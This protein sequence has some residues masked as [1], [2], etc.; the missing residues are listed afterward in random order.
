MRL[1]R[2]FVL[3]A[4]L[5]ML[6]ALP[7]GCFYD[8]CK[9][10]SDCPDGQICL[11][12]GACGLDPITCDDLQV[13]PCSG[14]DNGPQDTGLCAKEGRQELCVAGQFVTNQIEFEERL[15][16]ISGNTADYTD[17]VARASFV[18]CGNTPSGEAAVEL[19]N[20]EDD[21][22]DGTID[23]P[24]KLTDTGEPC[25][26]GGQGAC[27]QNGVWECTAG[28]R[29]CSAVDLDKQ[30]GTCDNQD[31]NCNGVV[32]EF[33]MD[34]NGDALAHEIPGDPNTTRWSAIDVDNVGYIAYEEQGVDGIT[35]IGLIASASGEAI[36]TI[37]TVRGIQPK[38]TNHIDSGGTESVLLYYVGLRES[39][40]SDGIDNDGD[41]LLDCEDE[42][43]CLNSDSRSS[44]QESACDDNQDD[45]GDNFTDCEDSQCFENVACKGVVGEEE[46][47][48]DGTDND[49][50]GDVDC[51]DRECCGD[52][53]CQGENASSNCLPEHCGNGVDDDGDGLSDCDDPECCTIAICA[54]AQACQREGGSCDNGTDDD[55]DGLAD[56]DDPDCCSFGPCN[57]N[58]VCIVEGC[59]DSGG[60][61]VDTDGD[62]FLGCEDPDCCDEAVCA[63]DNSCVVEDCTNAID[64]DN[65]GNIDCLDSECS[66]HPK[67]FETDCND[68]SDNDNDGNADCLD[69]DCVS[70]PNCRD[71]SASCSQGADFC[72]SNMDPGED[73]MTTDDDIA[74]D[75]DGDGLANCDDQSCKTGSTVCPSATEDCGNNTDDDNDGLIDCNDPECA[76]RDVSCVE[77][78]SNGIDDNADGNTDCDDIQCTTAAGCAEVCDN[79]NIDDDNNG[80]A[81]CADAACAG[82]LS[83]FENCSNRIDDDLDGLTDCD[84][85]DGCGGTIFCS[86]EL[87]LLSISRTSDG[88]YTDPVESCITCNDGVRYNGDFKRSP[89]F[90]TLSKLR[91]QPT[92]YMVLYNRLEPQEKT[93]LYSARVQDNLEVG[94]SVRKVRI[95]NSTF[96]GV[97]Y[98]RMTLFKGIDPH[99]ILV[100]RDESLTS[101]RATTGRITL[102]TGNIAPLDG[103]L[104]LDTPHA[105]A[106]L[107]YVM[108]LSKFETATDLP[109]AILADAAGEETNGTPEETWFA[110]YAAEEDETPLQYKLHIHSYFLRR[111]EPPSL[112]IDTSTTRTDAG[113]LIG[114]RD[115]D[116]KQTIGRNTADPDIIHNIELVPICEDESLVCR[117]IMMFF[118]ETHTFEGNDIT[119]AHAEI[120]DIQDAY[121]VTESD[122]TD[123]ENDYATA[124]GGSPL[125][126]PV[127]TETNTGKPITLHRWGM[128]VTDSGTGQIRPYIDDVSCDSDETAP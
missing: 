11:A 63:N 77:N 14:T 123:I 5:T 55:S 8:N 59:F 18:F 96:E 127:N 92:S 19:C 32:D 104:T 79:G 81:D 30:R 105:E 89:Q 51:D 93:S 53:A 107:P 90:F 62:G 126:F 23:N 40:C 94:T 56:C 86:Q 64:D 41:G 65:D 50:N 117:R 34:T 3:L 121:V 125:F 31:D 109:V 83:C 84:D 16:T 73:D 36:E 66:R 101:E 115:G 98:A 114:L 44:C 24:G 118:S 12:G 72:C 29:I 52:P 70:A 113:W 95:P 78:C 45:D 58:P 54:T 112:R 69:L 80:F 2:H 106:L 102:L 35:E 47:C 88:K 21:E 6:S 68:N 110:Y 60:A 74:I 7:T 22:C 108:D 120:L 119:E 9:V 87:K 43:D 57:G 67:C 48:G 27:A 71:E 116:I 33:A 37:A 91:D 10:D 122:Q 42:D 124:Q 39:N 1:Q 61:A 4:L 103:R 38:L 100:N 85:I 20:G 128:L 49:A 26:S 13:Q 99:I 15:A 46:L 25:E 82:T 76:L 111:L 28:Q 97:R 75:D 17:I